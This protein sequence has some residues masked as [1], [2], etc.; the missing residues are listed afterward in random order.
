MAVHWS[1]RTVPGDAAVKDAS[2]LLFGLA[3]TPFAEPFLFGPPPTAPP[4]PAGE[5]GRCGS[6][7][8]YM[9]RHCKFSC[10]RT[11]FARSWSC[12]LCLHENV[13]VPPRYADVATGTDHLA[14]LRAEVL[15]F[16]TGLSDPAGLIYLFVV[17]VSA[18]PAAVPG[19]MSEFVDLAKNCLLAALESIPRGSMVGLITVSDTVGVF[20][21]GSPLPGPHVKHVIVPESC[22]SRTDGLGIEE[23]LPLSRLLAPLDD[24]HEEMILQA[25]E[26]LHLFVSSARCGMGTAVRM[27]VDFVNAYH[28]LRGARVGLLM[29]NRPNWGVGSLSS[30]RLLDIEPETAFYA[31][32]A[33]LASGVTFDIFCHRA[34]AETL[35]LAAL[36]FLALRTGGVI[37]HGVNPQD[38]F[39]LYAVSTAVDCQMVVRTSPDVEVGIDFQ[40]DVKLASVSDRDTF[41]YQLEY[42]S[43]SGSYSE[44]V[45]VQ[46]AFQYFV[47]KEGRLHQ[48]LRVIT[49]RAKTSLSWRM[50]YPSVLPEVQ[51]ALLA[52]QL[53]RARF[54]DGVEEARGMLKRWL[55]KINTLCVSHNVSLGVFQ[56]CK[57]IPRFVFAL[58][59]S[60]ILKTIISSD[61]WISTQG[62]LVRLPPRDVLTFLY[63]ALSSW[64]TPEKM[65]TKGVH[66]SHAACA[67]TQC[68]FF[69]MDTFTHVIVRGNPAPPKESALRNE[70]EKIRKL[71][72]TG[73]VIVD[74]TGEV[75]EKHLLEESG[76]KDFLDEQSAM[77]QQTNKK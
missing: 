15:D 29:G 21:L 63:P 39:R 75:F 76:F 60:P 17:D 65:Q 42:S 59:Q 56:N 22:E 14:E 11:G 3:V 51:M 72:V 77:L 6:C 43:S 68:P 49:S 12:S 4:P 2:G 5:V 55:L 30:H 36:K 57:D 52:Q 58:L 26:N 19:S 70:V 48:Y 27:V 32:E 20:D 16:P 31:D 28:D 9:N 38:L 37:I 10:D 61:D 18:A 53:I 71:R 54:D 24:T 33:A 62:L 34:E 46:V 35:G 69:V 66:L 50:V 13:P 25:I 41:Y 67:A 1:S 73:D 7:G 8:G 74:T 44:Y 45:V 64:A 47:L 23:M 40:E